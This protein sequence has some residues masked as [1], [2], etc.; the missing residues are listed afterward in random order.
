[1]QMVSLASGLIIDAAGGA[2][3]GSPRPSQAGSCA[4]HG[5]R[6]VLTV[7]SP[8]AGTLRGGVCSPLPLSLSVTAA[9]ESGD[10]EHLTLETK[11]LSSSP[12]LSCCHVLPLRLKTLLWPSG[13][14]QGPSQAPGGGSRQGAPAL[15]G[16]HACSLTRK[17]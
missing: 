13:C 16:A 7:P 4:A 14:P 8:R 17:P 11:G 12:A 6:S 15:L 5:E 1:M 3:V 2:A 10:S 9:C